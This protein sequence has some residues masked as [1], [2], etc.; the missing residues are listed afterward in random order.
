[1]FKDKNITS[2]DREI[3][4][5]NY[6]KDTVKELFK[7]KVSERKKIELEIENYKMKNSKINLPKINFIPISAIKNN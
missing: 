6:W 7:P 1:M 3:R 4:M 2:K 5:K